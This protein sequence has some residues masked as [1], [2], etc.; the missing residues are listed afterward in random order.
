M[1]SKLSNMESNSFWDHAEELRTVLLR[2]LAL[3]LVAAVVAFCFKATLFGVVL[4]PCSSDFFT[5]RLLGAE[6]FSIRLINTGLTE[7]FAAHVKVA[8]AVGLLVAMPFLLWQLFGFMKPGLYVGERKTIG[9]LSLW[10]ALMFYVGVAVSYVLVFPLAVRFLGTYSVSPEVETMLTLHS[11]IDTLATL[12]LLMGVVFELPIACRM[13]GK[14]GVLTRSIMH[15]YRRHAVVTMLIVAAVVTPTTDMF[16]LLAV[17][18]PVWLLYE[19]SALIVD[20]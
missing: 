2:S 15:R 4:A 14:M 9:W 1:V 5:Y 12:S 7:Q 11:Y 6:D 13:L 16:S 8:A 20:R 18:L 3:M 17:T 19:V 10:T